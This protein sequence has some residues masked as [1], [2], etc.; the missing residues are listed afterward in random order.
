MLPQETHLPYSHAYTSEQGHEE[1]R[2][3]HT[4][5]WTYGSHDGAWLGPFSVRDRIAV[6]YSRWVWRPKPG[7]QKKIE[8]TRP[9]ACLVHTI[10]KS[11]PTTKSNAHPHPRLFLVTYGAGN[12]KS[13][14]Y[15]LETWWCWCRKDS[16]L[17]CQRAKISRRRWSLLL[18]EKTS[19]SKMIRC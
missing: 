13:S 18:S 9:H 2:R 5:A 16:L 10:K 14:A 1:T 19:L 12:N 11:S 8:W 17:A 15:T 6:F 4:H 7:Q 3:H